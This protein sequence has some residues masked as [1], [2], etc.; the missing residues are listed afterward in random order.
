MA[1]D[2]PEKLDNFSHPTFSSRGFESDR[3]TRA[4]LGEAGEHKEALV[5]TVDCSNG[6]PSSACKLFTFVYP[7][8]SHD[9]QEVSVFGNFTSVRHALAKVCAQPR[10]RP[11]LR[12]QRPR[13]Q[14][15]D[16]LLS[17]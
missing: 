13:A 5:P 7:H 6:T 3:P 11:Y 10:C 15:R 17:C 9:T 14:S 8:A 12:G 4:E 1:A 2:K 16:S